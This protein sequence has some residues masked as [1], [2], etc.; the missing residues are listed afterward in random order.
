MI[1]FYLDEMESQNI[2]AMVR[3]AGIDI[4]SS[5]ELRHEGMADTG[6]L[7]LAAR[8][9]RCVVSRNYDDFVEAT[10]VAERRGDPHSGVALIPTS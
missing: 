6:V 8:E 1:R 7:A 10:Y 5:H 3:D 9:R 2:A 4:V